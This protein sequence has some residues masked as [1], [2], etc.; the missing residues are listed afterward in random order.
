[1]GIEIHM[2]LQM[3]S[4]MI[5]STEKLKTLGYVLANNML[6]VFVAFKQQLIIP[7]EMDRVKWQK[8]EQLLK[9]S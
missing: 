9:I 8:N 1:M 6:L 7:W 5:I 3:S 2:L 4:I